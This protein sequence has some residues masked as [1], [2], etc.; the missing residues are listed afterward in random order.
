MQSP[1]L[2]EV[3][4]LTREVGDVTRA[5][6]DAI[7]RAIFLGLNRDRC[8]LHARYA[9]DSFVLEVSGRKAITHV[10]QCCAEDGQHDVIIDFAPEIAKRERDHV[11]SRTQARP[12]AEFDL[13]T[14]VEAGFFRRRRGQ[15]LTL[16]T[17]LEL[18]GDE[19]MH[20]EHAARLREL[21]DV[22]PNRA[23]LSCPVHRN[24]AIQR[25]HIELQTELTLVDLEVC[26][27]ETHP[28]VHEVCVLVDD[29]LLSGKVVAISAGKFVRRKRPPKRKP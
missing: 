4:L 9:V 20:E 6:R 3:H 21:L 7:E 27:T 16:E 25:T 8:P 1:P 5:T 26:C 13:E 18:R 2:H 28:M 10:T 14:P 19:R 11:I 15:R 29:A 12:G 22:P 24:H 23:R 17:T